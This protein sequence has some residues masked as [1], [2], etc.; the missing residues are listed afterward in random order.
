MKL[1]KVKNVAVIGAGQT[2]IDISTYLV[3]NNINVLLS[4]ANKDVII[5]PRLIKNSYFRYEIGKNSEKCLESDL[6]IP[7]PGV[8]PAN[9]ILI[10]AK[11]NDLPVL[12]EIEFAFLKYTEKRTYKNIVAV[13][14]TNGKTSTVQMIEFILNKSGIKAVACGNIG[15]P[16]INY[17]NY[18][19]IIVLEVSSFQLHYSFKFR[20]YIS[21]LLNIDEDHIEWHKTFQNYIEAK[22]K[23]FKN[24]N[25][26]D[27]MVLNFDDK[28][29]LDLTKGIRVRKYY[30]SQTPLPLCKNEFDTATYEFENG[31]ILKDKKII[32]IINYKKYNE[33]EFNISGIQG[34]FRKNA[35]ASLLVCQI[36]GID[37]PTG[38]KKLSDF[39][40][41]DHRLETFYRNNGIT[42]I[43]DSK[44]TNPLSVIAAIDSMNDKFVLVIGGYEKGLDYKNVKNRIKN[45]LCVGLILYGPLGK[46][47]HKEFSKDLSIKTILVNRIDDTIEAGVE[48]LDGSGI[49][50]F[51]PG[52]SSFDSFDN[53]KERGDYFKRRVREWLKTKK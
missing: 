9:K 6:I 27:R 16:F 28:R 5:N 21:V 20:P 52:T 30:F 1:N 32:H 2:G 43:N 53:Y 31:L 35:L 42:Y 29:V 17:V 41:G 51:S 3:K 10:K 34:I 46:R 50:L 38:I 18:K 40:V 48:I 49:F 11:K 22:R 8:S 7:S 15:D 14:G 45:S 19:G 13:T 44:S 24:Q 36:L 23:L 26:K 25:P 47:I 33:Y 39:S 37:V 12:S 4:E